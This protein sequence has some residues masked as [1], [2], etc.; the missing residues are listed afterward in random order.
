MKLSYYRERAAINT[1]AKFGF[2]HERLGPETPGRAS[3]QAAILDHLKLDPRSPNPEPAFSNVE[4]EPSKVASQPEPQ[5]GPHPT[6]TDLSDPKTRA[7]AGAA[8]TLAG[9]AALS[10]AAPYI[11]GRKTL[12]HGTT[13]EALDSIY[14]RG[15]LPTAQVSGPSI[16]DQIPDHLR[17][18]AKKLVYLTPEKDM[19]RGYALQAKGLRDGS[20]RRNPAQRLYDWAI[21]KNNPFSAAPVLEVA[22]PTWRR[23]IQEHLRPNPEA[24]GSRL[25]FLNK[26]GLGQGATYDHLKSTVNLDVPVNPKYIKGHAGYQRFSPRELAEYAR[27]KPLAFTGGVLGGAAGLAATGYGLNLLREAYQTR[28][29]TSSD[30]TTVPPDAMSR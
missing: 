12:Y 7:I 14:K 16:I 11:T 4:G 2:A 28:R 9:G 20:Y 5:V 24:L 27:A 1:L 23:E 29:Q 3:V 6:G 10:K 30:P 17:E 18:A 26:H 22:L 15:I 13:H 8:S 25:E 21:G 19:A